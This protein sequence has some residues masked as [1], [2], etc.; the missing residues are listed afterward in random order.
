MSN[1]KKV[2]CP[3]C[4][5]EVFTLVKSLS[6]AESAKEKYQGICSDCITPEEQEEM[7]KIQAEAMYDH[8][9]SAGR[10]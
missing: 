9:S 8:C 5:K 1:V 2:N 7:M 6:G 3:R 10:W 4:N